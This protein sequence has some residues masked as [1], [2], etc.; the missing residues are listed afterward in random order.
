MESG[1]IVNG[2]GGT[3]EE[4]RR[5]KE[6][7]GIFSL[8]SLFLKCVEL[9]SCFFFLHF[10]PRGKNLFCKSFCNAWLFCIA[11]RPFP[12][13]FGEKLDVSLVTPGSGF[14]PLRDLR[15]K[16]QLMS[17]V[18]YFNFVHSSTRRY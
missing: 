16:S 15:E 10:T 3:V 5:R 7:E 2:E 11:G 18:L 1:K 17:N 6:K 13:L 4:S 9:L 14:P 12:P 8:F